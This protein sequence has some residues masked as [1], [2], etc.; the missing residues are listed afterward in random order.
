MHAP[1]WG[2]LSS[3]LD[4]KAL[5]GGPFVVLP[6]AAPL[7]IFDRHR[8]SRGSDGDG[9]RSSRARRRQGVAGVDEPPRDERVPPDTPRH[10]NGCCGFGQ[11]RF[12]GT[13]AEIPKGWGT[14]RSL[15]AR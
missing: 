11:R 12:D 9:R 10:Q 5:G 13:W 4:R 1:G 8:D 14:G 6:A 2:L 15:A 7:L 3:A